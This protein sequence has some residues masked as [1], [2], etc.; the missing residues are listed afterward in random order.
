MHE[1]SF[2]DILGIFTAFELLVLLV[3]GFFKEEDG[4]PD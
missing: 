4:P 1:L 2:W 3:F